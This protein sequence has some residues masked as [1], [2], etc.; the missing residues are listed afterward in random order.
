MLA[1]DPGILRVIGIPPGWSDSLAR[2]RPRR[3]VEMARRPGRWWHKF[4]WLAGRRKHKAF[5][6]ICLYMLELREVSD[7][8]NFMQRLA[9]FRREQRGKPE[10]IR[11]LNEAGLIVPGEPVAWEDLVAACPLPVRRRRDDGDDY[12]FAVLEHDLFPI[13]ADLY[14][15]E[16]IPF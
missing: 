13:D 8:E 10:L 11:F 9:N 5:R 15:D 16:E 4:N 7:P 12:A 3:M 14:S 6:R 1:V 2:T